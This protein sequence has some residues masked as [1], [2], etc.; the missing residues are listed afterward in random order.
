MCSICRYASIVM[1]EPF[2]AAVSG[3]CVRINVACVAARVESCST[4]V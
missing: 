4:A 2:E 1:H 3:D